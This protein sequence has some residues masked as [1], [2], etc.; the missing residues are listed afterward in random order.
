MVHIGFADDIIADNCEQIV[1]NPKKSAFF[2]W[3]D[4]SGGPIG[5][6]ERPV[7]GGEAVARGDRIVFR[8]ERDACSEGR[9][10]PRVAPDAFRREIFFGG[11]DRR[12]GGLLF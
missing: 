10:S 2:R 12:P 4:E 5:R 9:L 8:G 3:G 11:V 6:G 7:W 1:N